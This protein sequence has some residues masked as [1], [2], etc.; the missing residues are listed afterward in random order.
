[1]AK[2]WPPGVAFSAIG[3]LTAS[4][5]TVVMLD[6]RYLRG[7]KDMRET[8]ARILER[9]GLKDAASHTRRLDPGMAHDVLSSDPAWTRQMLEENVEH[10]RA[11]WRSRAAK[12]RAKKKAKGSS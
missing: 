4:R 5:Y 8:I 9:A 2:I 7:A 1:M 12:H 3:M 6:R 11:G 10:L